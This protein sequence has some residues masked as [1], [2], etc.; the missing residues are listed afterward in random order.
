[1]CSDFLGNFVAIDDGFPNSSYLVAVVVAFEVAIAIVA[2]G[3]E[4]AIAADVEVVFAAVAVV[5][6]VVAAG[7]PA[8]VVVG[9]VVVVAVD[10][11][12]EDID[13]VAAGIAVD[14]VEVKL[15]DYSRY[16]SKQDFTSNHDFDLIIGQDKISF[17]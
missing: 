3:F 6:L 17:D 1:M 2:A 12:I 11:C 8:V 5:A 16:F 13:F 7:K 14:M 10:L 15:I 9:I 4:F